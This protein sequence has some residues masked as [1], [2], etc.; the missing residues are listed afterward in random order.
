MVWWRCSTMPYQSGVGDRVE[1]AVLDGADYHGA[2]A[3]RADPAVGR[4]V[5]QRDVDV[6]EPAPGEVARPVAGALTDVGPH[7]PRAQHRRARIPESWSANRSITGRAARTSRSGG[8]AASSRAR[9]VAAAS[10]P[11]SRERRHDWTI[12]TPTPQDCGGSRSG[13]PAARQR[14]LTSSVRRHAARP[15]MGAPPPARISQRLARG[16]AS[17]RLTAVVLLAN[18]AGRTKRVRLGTGA[19]I[20]PWNDP[21]RVA[22]KVIMLDRPQAVVAQPVRELG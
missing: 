14:S 8:T 7:C 18:A 9:S 11:L 16:Q 4:V 17:D 2:R 21:L 1:V 19:V 15:R 6:G 10:T 12:S 20:L 3:L 22:E 5:F 13:S